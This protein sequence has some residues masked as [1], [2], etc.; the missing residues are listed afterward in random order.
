GGSS[1]AA[2]LNN[3]GQVAGTSV[4]ADAS[5]HAFVWDRATGMRDVMAFSSSNGYL[6]TINDAG[7]VWG[8]ADTS[9]QLGRLFIRDPNDGLVVSSKLPP[10]TYSLYDLNNHSCFLTMHRFKRT[11]RR[12]A[13]LWHRQTGFAKLW[14]PEGYISE[15]AMINDANQVVGWEDIE[16][17]PLKLL[18][19]TFFRNRRLKR[20]LILWDPRYGRIILNGQIP[21][22]MRKHF[23]V[24]DLNNAG[25]ILGLAVKGEK[26]SHAVLLEP[27][28]EK[29]DD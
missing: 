14:C 9:S 7:L 19:R 3:H 15:P 10:D 27:I 29:W 24:R 8:Y 17:R 11:E 20:Q 22:G 18:G 28:P 25:V 12:Y 4:T 16:P 5:R 1:E 21:W 23:T 6:R 13:V 26:S 2:A